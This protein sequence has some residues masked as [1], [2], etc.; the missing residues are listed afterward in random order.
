MA[1]APEHANTLTPCS[2]LQI[3]VD[4][5]MKW[6]EALTRSL[7]LKGPYDGFYLSYKVSGPTPGRCPVSHVSRDPGG[8]P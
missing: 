8:Q 3:S 1:T 2:P 5:G 6:E 4:R 7:E